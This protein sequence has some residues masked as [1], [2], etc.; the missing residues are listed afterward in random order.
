MAIATLN[1]TV[2]SNTI[3]KYHEHKSTCKCPGTYYPNGWLDG[4]GIA[5]VSCSVCGG[6]WNQSSTVHNGGPCQR[7]ICGKTETTVESITIN[8]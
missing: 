2:T 1:I 8:Y 3:Y 5:M 7:I 6:N 4:N